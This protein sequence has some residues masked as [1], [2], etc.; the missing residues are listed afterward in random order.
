MT[1]AVTGLE[2]CVKEAEVHAARV[3]S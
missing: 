2:A 1:S 3:A